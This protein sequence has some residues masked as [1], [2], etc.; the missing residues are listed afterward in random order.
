MSNLIE[1]HAFS[2][3]KCGTSPEVIV[4]DGKYTGPRKSKVKKLLELQ[5]S[6]GDSRKLQQSTKYAN[7]VFLTN[8][9]ERKAILELLTGDQTMQDFVEMANISSTNGLMVIEIVRHILINFPEELPN[10]YK[11]IIAN[12]CKSTSV[13]GFLQVLSEEP[14]EILAEYCK[15]NLSLRSVGAQY[16]LN[17]VKSSLPALWPDLDNICR[18]EDIEYLPNSISNV[19]LKLIE[20]RKLTFKNLIWHRCRNKEK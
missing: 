14:L 7:R 16:Q 20:I 8:N 11:N 4:G 9:R 17:I 5:P 19:L 2:C 10:C 13:R 15:R 6:D 18:L 1:K 12:I 3:P